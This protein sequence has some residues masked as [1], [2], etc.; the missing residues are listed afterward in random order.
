VVEL[1]IA[2][3]KVFNTPDDRLIFDV[4]H[5]CYPHKI[6]TGRRDR[7]RTLR[8]EGGL[9]GFTKR[10]ESEYDPF[11]AAH[12]STSIS[13]G[14]GM[15]VAAELSHT[16]RNVIAV[17]GDGALTSGMALEALNDAGHA[18]LN[19]LVVL[20]DNAMS[21]SPNVGAMARYL[22]RARSEPG[23]LRAKEQFESLMRRLPSGGALVELLERLKSGV[24][25]IF[26]PGMLFEDLGFTYLGPLDGHDIPALL[27][28]LSQAKRL[29]GPVLVH[30]LTEK[31]KGYSPAEMHCSR[32]HGVAAFDLET[33]EPI[34]PPHGNT[35]TE[36]FG[37]IVNTLVA[38]DD[39]VVA[40]TAAM[41]D[42]TG[43]TDFKRHHPARFFDVGM[44]EEHA[45]TLA[46]GL[47]CEGLRPVVAIYSTFLQRAYDQVLHDVCLQQ[48]PVILAIDRAG[49]VGEDGPTHQGAFDLS[50]LRMMP[51]LTLMAPATFHE[52]DAML[53]HALTLPGPSAIRYPKG[54]AGIEDAG[55]LT[56]IADGRAAVLRAGDDVALLAVGPIVSAALTAADLMQAQGIRAGVMNARFVKPLDAATILQVARQVRLVVTVEE[57]VIAGG[58]GS[59]VQQLFAEHHI[60]APCRAIGLPDFFPNQGSRAQLLTHFGL[61]PEGIAEFV[62]QQLAAA[63][64]PQA[65]VETLASSHTLP[66]V[67]H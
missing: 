55:P 44:A 42:G 12:S 30:V 56:T 62:V 5:Q 37:T 25:Q 11:G 49:V 65:A 52:L 10:A 46:A 66:P 26:I 14:L 35:F 2:I 7:I 27:S 15:A 64:R 48:L 21:I 4:G 58:F 34:E 18:N 1:T 45:V 39:R 40:I 33:G 20:N 16:D 29:E 50:Y 43:L 57:N 9:S 8:Q 67:D 54:R 3:H 53:T 60:T 22:S 23:Y 19:L 31:G 61:H 28:A 32:L 63:P 47:A 59:A 38:Q 13:A 51:H 6:L 36:Q 24:K 41:C 17:I